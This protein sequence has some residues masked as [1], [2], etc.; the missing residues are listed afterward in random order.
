MVAA[1]EPRVPPLTTEKLQTEHPEGTRHQAKIDIA[2]SLIGNG[3]P[4]DDVAAILRQRFPFARDKEIESLIGW[5]TEHDPQPSGGDNYH[6]H[7]KPENFMRGRYKA[8]EAPRKPDGPPPATEALRRVRDWLGG[9][10][11]SEDDL[12]YASPVKPSA[13]LATDATVVFQFLY[14]KGDLINV[15][16]DY[17]ETTN[18]EGRKKANPHGPGKILSAGAWGDWIARHGVPVM[19]AGTW[20]RPNPLVSESGSGKGGAVTDKDIAAFRFVLLESDCLPLQVQLT[21]MGVFKLPIAV[22]LTS[23]GA[24]Y[25]AWVRIDAE[26]LQQYRHA[27]ERLLKAVEPF[28]FDIANKNPSRLSRLP[29]VMRGIRHGEGM[30]GSGWSI[31]IQIP[32]GRRFCE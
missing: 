14:E 18:A 5:A 32:N 7:R 3:L 6:G 27:A 15:V 16:C 2:M 1:T 26:N 19:K 9:A 29:G 24:S 25:H 11:A 12:V 8:P 4:P 31:S 21:A 30:E 22:I 17:T 28:G 20:V 10:L 23:G 13:V